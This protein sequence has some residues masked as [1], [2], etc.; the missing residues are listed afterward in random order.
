MLVASMVGSGRLGVLVFILTK[1][2]IM[3]FDPSF[4][5]LRGRAGEQ[6]DPIILQSLGLMI[7][8]YVLHTK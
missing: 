8:R 5:P 4:H 1:V 2:I 6:R 7:L 3:P